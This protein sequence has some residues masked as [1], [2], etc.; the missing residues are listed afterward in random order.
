MQLSIIIINHN[1]LALT[2]QTVNS[3]INAQPQIDYEIIIVDNSTEPTQIFHPALNAEKVT[4][5]LA[6]VPNKGFSHGC[7]IGAENAHGQYLLFLN[8]DT[9]M[10]PYTLEK[11]LAYIKQNK[12]IGALGVKT[13]LADGTLD[14]ACKRGFPTP[15]NAIC[16]FTKLDQLFP[17]IKVFNRYHLTYLSP[18]ETHK[19]DAIAG[20]Y[21]MLP[22]KLYH[23]LGGFDETFFMYGEDLDLCYRIK[24]AGYDIVYYADAYI[25]HL[26]GK[27][28]TQSNNKL[29]KYHF[30]NAM[31]LFYDKHY[32][33]AYPCIVSWGIYLV[34]W[35]LKA[36]TKLQFISKSLIKVKH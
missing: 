27:S 26:K 20:A 28:V 9:I 2:T 24:A 17:K 36:K 13:L 7:N 21:L 3:I 10:Y 5:V 11:S 32:K 23:E 15:F 31:R 34:L 6:N 16:Y 4:K 30:Y 8:S 33:E 35:F 25:T 18:N 19:I 29:M 14:K 12:N 22:T 1:T